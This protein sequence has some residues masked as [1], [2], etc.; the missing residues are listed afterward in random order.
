MLNW[1]IAKTV[2][3]DT[4]SP[5]AQT[6]LSQIKDQAAQIHALVEQI[7]QLPDFDSG[8]L[9]IGESQAHLGV[10]SLVR[11]VGPKKHF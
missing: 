3:L 4:L 5:E 11:A 1:E 8:W 9:R 6:L 2:N 10:T 7:R